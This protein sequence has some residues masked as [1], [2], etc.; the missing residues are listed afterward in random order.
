MKYLILPPAGSSEKDGTIAKC[1]AGGAQAMGNIILKVLPTIS[2]GGIHYL[3]VNSENHRYMKY[4]L[5]LISGSFKMGRNTAEFDA[6]SAQTIRTDI[7]K[8]LAT[9]FICSR[10]ISI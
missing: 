6:D 5:L 7:W 9:N 3:F 8:A 2:I 10:Y 4:L 1:S